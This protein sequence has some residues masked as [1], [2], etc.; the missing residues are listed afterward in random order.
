MYRG[1]KGTYVYACNKGLREYL[2]IYIK[3]FNE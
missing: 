2:K 1:I 3:E